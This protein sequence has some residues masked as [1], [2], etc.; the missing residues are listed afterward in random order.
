MGLKPGSIIKT[1]QVDAYNVQKPR[2]SVILVQ[3]VPIGSI[4]A[5]ISA[6]YQQEFFFYIFQTFYFDLAP[7]MGMAFDDAVDG[8]KRGAIRAR[9]KISMTLAELSTFKGISAKDCTINYK[10]NNFNSST[11]KRISRSES[12]LPGCL[13]R[14]LS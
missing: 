5:E 6:Q 14:K 3:P 13:L 12:M 8:C 11:V 9:L 10:N 2:R 7:G 4:P 1:K